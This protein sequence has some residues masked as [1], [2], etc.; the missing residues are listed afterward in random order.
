MKTFNR[1]LPA[2]A[3]RFENLEKFELTNVLQNSA[4][5]KH[6]VSTIVEKNSIQSHSRFRQKHLADLISVGI[7]STYL[8]IQRRDVRSI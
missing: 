8:E 4:L 7:P 5:S 6:C 1:K 2:N 3:I